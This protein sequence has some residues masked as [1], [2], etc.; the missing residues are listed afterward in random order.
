[1]S[2]ISSVS[3]TAT[4]DL[5]IEV[6]VDVTAPI[7]GITLGR[8]CRPQAYSIAEGLPELG[9]TP[10]SDGDVVAGISFDDYP[11]E[12]IGFIQIAGIT[13]VIPANR[14]QTG[15]VTATDI[16]KPL[17]NVAAGEYALTRTASTD[18]YCGVITYIDSGTGDF[19]FAIDFDKPPIAGLAMTD[20][21]MEDDAAA[22]ETITDGETVQLLGGNGIT[23]VATNTPTAM[24]FSLPTST[25]DETGLYY[26]LTTA[27]WKVTEKLGGAYTNHLQLDVEGNLPSGY[28]GD[29]G[30]LA[31]ADGGYGYANN[32]LISNG[33]SGVANIWLSGNG[34]NASNN[35]YFSNAAVSGDYPLPTVYNQITGT[36]LAG[37]A[38]AIVLSTSVGTSRPTNSGTEVALYEGNTLQVGTSSRTSSVGGKNLNDTTKYGGV[39]NN[40]IGGLLTFGNGSS[41]TPSSGYVSGSQQTEAST[42]GTVSDAASWFLGAASTTGSNIDQ[43]S[44]FRVYRLTLSMQ[45]STDGTYQTETITIISNLSTATWSVSDF[46]STG[47]AASEIDFDVDF[48]TPAGSSLTYMRLRAFNTLVGK[49][50]Q[51]DISGQAIGGNLI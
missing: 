32:F 28:S 29:C 46:L 41:T 10:Y 33:A 30:F 17:F 27:G 26:D 49:N 42:S 31:E 23:T 16:G 37:S 2:Q 35:I 11:R 40:T 24:T 48:P 20:W 1:M 5:F 38:Q 44:C 19:Q 6:Y 3:S 25:N 15:L 45:N 7:I 50:V 13:P 9:A 8:P 43:H 51:Y 39:Q 4:E 21:I 22:T 18:P 12:S 47:A 14:C 36:G 34:A